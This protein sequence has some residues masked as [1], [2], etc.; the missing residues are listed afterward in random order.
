M[1][2]GFIGRYLTWIGQGS[3]DVVEIAAVEAVTTIRAKRLLGEFGSAVVAV[4]ADA[5]G[6]ATGRLGRGVANFDDAIGGFMAGYSVEH[7]DVTVADSGAFAEVVNYTKGNTHT[8]WHFGDIRAETGIETFLRA[9][10]LVLR[11]N[12]GFRSVLAAGR[13]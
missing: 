3:L 8:V 11:E 13:P 6:F 5:A 4:R 1:P 12:A 7:A 10:G 2:T 9:A